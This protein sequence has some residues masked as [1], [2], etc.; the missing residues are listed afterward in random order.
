MAFLFSSYSQSHSELDIVSLESHEEV[1]FENI[2]IEDGLSQGSVRSIFQDSKGFMWFASHDGLNR[3]DGYKFLVFRNSGS[4]TNSISNNYIY[5]IASDFTGNL[6]VGTISGLNRY[7]HA[8]QSF[9]RFYLYNHNGALRENHAI[10]HVFSSNLPDDPLVYFSTIYGLYSINVLTYE[11]QQIVLKIPYPISAKN[12]IKSSFFDRNGN[13]WLGLTG[14]GIIKYNPN[15]HDSQF[16]AIETYT[17]LGQYHT[18]VNGISDTPDGNILAATH[19]GLVLIDNA[20]CRIIHRISEADGRNYWYLGTQFNTICKESEGVYWLGSNGAGVTKYD[21]NKKT[22]FYYKSNKDDPNSLLNGNIQSLFVD[23]SGILWVGTFGDGISRINPH[24]NRFNLYSRRPGGIS[25]KGMRTIWTDKENNLWIGGYEGLEKFDRSKNKVVFYQNIFMNLGYKFRTVYSSCP[26]VSDPDRFRWLGS[27]GGGIFLFDCKTHNYK[28]YPFSPNPDGKSLVG[29]YVYSLYQDKS[30]ILWAGTERGLNRIDVKNKTNTFFEHNTNDPNSIGPKT[31]YSILEDRNGILWLGTDIGGLNSYNRYTGKFTR[32]T[33]II[34]DS[35]SISSN[36]IFS[37]LEDSKG[38]LWAGTNGSGLNLFDRQTYKFKHFTTADGLPNNV[39]YAIIE[40]SNGCLWMST[41]YGISRFNTEANTFTNYDSR[42]GLQSNEFNTASYFKTND[43][44]IF[45]GGI[46]GLNSFYPSKLIQNTTPPQ[47]V[48]TDFR[49][50]GLSVPIGK[51]ANGKIILN[52]SISY[53]DTVILDYTVNEFTFEFSALDYASSSKNRYKY[54]LEGFDKDWNFANQSRTASYTNLD[55]GVYTFRVLGSNND[56]F[57]N[58]QGASIVVIITPPF[59]K[60]LWFEILVGLIVI[61]LAISFYSLRVNRIKKYNK[62]L[63]KEVKDRTAELAEAN[64]ILLENAKKLKQL[65]AT[66]DKFFSIIGHDLKN[67]LSI[68]ITSTE[69][70]ANPSYE[71][72]KEETIEFSNEIHHTS[73]RL[74]ELL[75][76]LLTWARSQTNKLEYRPRQI[77]LFEITTLNIYLLKPLADDKLITLES[78]IPAVTYINC[79]DNMVKTI[80]RNLVSN[81]IKFTPEGGRITISVSDDTE[82]S[83][84]LIV[85]VQ[86][87]GVGMP[88]AVIEKLFRIDVSV[89]TAGTKNEKGTGLGLILCREFVERWNGRIWAESTPGIGSSFNFTVPKW[90]P[91]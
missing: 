79:D 85:T 42:D 63:E 65:N 25:N 12:Y 83:D 66:K 26:E 4:D 39:I 37:I 57:W 50:F 19:F 90:I 9:K 73:K 51:S 58:D 15:T 30:G 41:N 11:I 74:L 84:M 31:V 10:Y 81:A 77:E 1:N 59:W 47:V 75:N 28:P 34:G 64:G 14:S 36:Y 7:D 23:R 2:T 33:H 27:E 48:F 72:S 43:G 87:T 53:A 55:P 44:E 67:P 68:L 62:R 82:S 60:T 29:A 5:S 69:I 78:V 17:N 49:V 56:G 32:Y 61:V 88:E 18:L 91:K 71:L 3:Y 52:E 8:T 22:F 89:T 45:F 46:K 16:L 76:N 35:T 80:I 40:D 13:F 86:D 70:L 21:I 6:W 38:R 54:I 20:S 24:F